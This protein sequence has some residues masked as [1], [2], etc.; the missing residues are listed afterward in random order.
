MCFL[1]QVVDVELPTIKRPK[2]KATE[3]DK[4]EFSALFDSDSDDNDTDL[5]ERWAI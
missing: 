4:L 2:Q 1:S 5:T 3:E